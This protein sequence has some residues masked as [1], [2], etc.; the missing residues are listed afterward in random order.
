M[1]LWI[2]TIILECHLVRITPVEFTLVKKICQKRHPSVYVINNK[3]RAC[4]LP[5]MESLNKVC[6]L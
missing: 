5:S 4:G 6:N 2:G 3:F 1:D